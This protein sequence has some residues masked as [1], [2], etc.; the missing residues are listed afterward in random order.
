MEKRQINRTMTAAHQHQL[1]K[2][3]E[4]LEEEKEAKKEE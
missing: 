2:R 1:L 3:H 4:E